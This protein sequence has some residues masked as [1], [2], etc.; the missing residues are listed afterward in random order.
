MMGAAV[1]PATDV[2]EHNDSYEYKQK[3]RH[4]GKE[5]GEFTNKSHPCGEFIYY[6]SAKGL[7]YSPEMTD[8]N[9]NSKLN[10]YSK[11][12]AFCPA[13]ANLKSDKDKT[14]QPFDNFS[15]SEF[16]VGA[17]LAP[18]LVRE[19]EKLGQSCAYAHIS[20]GGVSISHFFTNEMA[21][22]YEE[23]IA[24]YN[25]N[26]NASLDANTRHDQLC[27]DSATAF[28]SKISDFFEDSE[29]VFAG[30]D[31]SVKA[32][33]WCQGENDALY[34]DTRNNYK[35]KLE[36]LWEKMTGLGF[37]HF[38]LVRIGFWDGIDTR[39]IM[40]AQ[41]EFCAENKDA[42][43]LTRS[44]SY[45]PYNGM[46]EGKFYTRSPED[47]YRN[48][49]DSYHGFDNLHIN[50]KGFQAIADHA[51]KNLKAVLLDNTAPSLEDE[52]VR[53]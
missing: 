8:K 22:Q 11:N 34:N 51:S 4:I 43:M 49:R 30:D 37:T 15:E 39:E 14:T 27:N 10:A 23:K 32:L 52:I 50:Q 41:E 33:I 44:M 48:C 29:K 17:T 19:W 31:I 25:A 40:L 7:A 42:Y 24:A 1:Y 9:G 38:F 20:K 28:E 16:Q 2:F 6:P 18:L 21:A 36:V 46:D 13:M 12:C 47:E 35:H 26:N 3:P 5:T 53:F 45:M